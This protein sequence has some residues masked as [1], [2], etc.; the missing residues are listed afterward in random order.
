[1]FSTTTTELSTSIP[2]ATARPESEIILI[3]T[4]EKYMSTMAKTRLSGIETSVMIV[5]RQSRRNKNST[6]TENSAPHSSDERI[7]RTMRLM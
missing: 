7:V 4:P 5:G 6:S 1:M 2:T 3:V